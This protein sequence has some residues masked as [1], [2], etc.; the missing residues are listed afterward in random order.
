ML[1]RKLPSQ[2]VIFMCHLNRIYHITFT[3]D[4]VY[5]SLTEYE[6]ILDSSI[7]DCCVKDSKYLTIR[8]NS[9]HGD[10]TF[11]DI[12]LRCYSPANKILTGKYIDSFPPQH[13][14]LSAS[15]S[16]NNKSY[17]SDEPAIFFVLTDKSIF[18]NHFKLNI[19][20][21]D[22]KSIRGTF[23]GDLYFEENEDITHLKK[24]TITKGGFYLPFKKPK[25]Q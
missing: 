19:N 2:M 23:C 8:A 17:F 4:G 6:V 16:V 10:T 22:K 25:I 5:H 24:I 11:L 20:S 7:N 14:L 3:V 9:S 15:Y 13:Y 18:T 21:I 12:N 1:Q